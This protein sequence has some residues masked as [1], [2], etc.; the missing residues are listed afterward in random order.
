[1]AFQVLSESYEAFGILHRMEESLQVFETIFPR[2]GCIPS[3]PPPCQPSGLMIHT[4]GLIIHVS[5]PRQHEERHV[6][7][8]YF[9][10]ASNKW[11][12][13]PERRN[14]NSKNPELLPNQQSMDLLRRLN[15]LDIEFYQ[16]AEALFEA[17]LGPTLSSPVRRR[18]LM[19]YMTIE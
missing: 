3:D 18:D 11:R 14:A 9:E 15:A 4:L 7:N 6:T 16:H 5:A 13:G 2:Q 12:S 19:D 10:G 1:M 17:R 8:M